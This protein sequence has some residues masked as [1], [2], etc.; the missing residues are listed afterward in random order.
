MYYRYTE[1]KNEM[2]WSEVETHVQAMILKNWIYYSK[3]NRKQKLWGTSHV[4]SI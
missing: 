4:C 1:I 3:L 2:P